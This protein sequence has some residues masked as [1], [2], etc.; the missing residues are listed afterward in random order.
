[1]RKEAGG[2]IARTTDWQIPRHQ[3]RQSLAAGGLC[4]VFKPVLK[5]L[6]VNCVMA[7]DNVSCL[8][9]IQGS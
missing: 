5:P 2:F 6:D 3:V 7:R 9:V 4:Q 1:M 8:R